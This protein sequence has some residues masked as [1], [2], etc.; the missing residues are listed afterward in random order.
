MHRLLIMTAGTGSM[1]V[2]L[3]AA[4][5][6]V[7]ALLLAIIV[8]VT[9]AMGWVISDGNRTERLATLIIAARSR[10]AEYEQLIDDATPRAKGARRSARRR[11]VNGSQRRPA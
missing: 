7:A 1:L 3:A 9:G 8:V 2:G 10:S 5:W 6:P 4:G 11:R